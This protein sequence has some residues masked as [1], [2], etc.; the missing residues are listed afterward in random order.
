MLAN[1]H[2]VLGA[3]TGSVVDRDALVK[4][5]L[6]ISGTGEDALLDLWIAACITQ[7]EAYCQRFFLQRTVTERLYEELPSRH[8]V[9]SSAPVASVT[10]IV[11]S[12]GTTVPAAEYSFDAAAAIITFDDVGHEFE[13]DY[14]VTY[15][16]G[17]LA[18]D[19]PASIKV[20][21]L[22]MV[23]QARTAKS[24]DYEAVIRQSPDIGTVT[25]RGAIPGITSANAGALS[26]LPPSVQRGLMPYRRR[27]A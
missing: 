19:I 18:A 10:S 13:G 12:G 2:I 11:D 25:Y 22:E 9:L 24:R 7:A 1:R 27:W 17:W 5:Y 8:L 4:P 3:P 15:V 21:I 23:K 14:T 6:G 20:A 16:A 26:E